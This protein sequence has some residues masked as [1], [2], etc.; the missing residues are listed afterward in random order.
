MEA[1]KTTAPASA[2][3]A[4]FAFMGWLTT[5]H[6]SVTLSR[7]HDAA[8]AAELVG[9]F[10]E[11]NGF[12]EPREGWEKLLVHP[13]DSTKDLADRIADD[14]FTN[15]QGEKARYLKMERENGSYGGGWSRAAVVDRI[16]EHLKR[17]TTAKAA[18]QTA[19]T[20]SAVRDEVIRAR[21]KFPTNKH[22]LAALMEEVGELAEALL[23]AEAENHVRDY[24][25]D[26]RSEAIQ[27][28]TVA[29]RIIEEGDH[30]FGFPLA[31]FEADGVNLDPE[32]TEF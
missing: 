31:Y 13:S 17:D 16:R 15:G 9:V 24:L 20:L 26:V 5:R 28:A 18:S 19:E 27:V 2:S 3:E 8:V 22:L 12:A 6:K 1:M 14:L 30:D 23:I 25:D 21:H 7:Y 4:L 29:V 10:C 11:A 32:R